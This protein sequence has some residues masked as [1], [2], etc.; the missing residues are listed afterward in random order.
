MTDVNGFRRRIT[1]LSD[2]YLKAL[3]DILGKGAT[4]RNEL[5][6]SNHDV[7]EFRK[8]VLLSDRHATDYYL[9]L[10]FQKYSHL[11][12]PDQL[13]C[14]R[15]K[16]TRQAIRSLGQLGELISICQHF[17]NRGL[18][19]T[20]IKGPHLARMLYGNSAVKVS[21]DLDILMVNPENLFDF[22]SVFINAGYS[23]YE[24]KLLTGSWKQK[25]YISAKREVHYFK[26]KSGCTIDL[27]VKP[28]ANTIITQHWCRNFFS[29]LQY[30]PFEGITIP[31]MPP[32]KYF[33][34]L[35][36]HGASHQFSRLGWLLD[37]RN[38]YNRQIEILRIDIILSV[39][40]Y[41]NTQRS[42]YLTFYLLEGMFND[43]MPEKIKKAMGPTGRTIEWL[44]MNCLKSISYEKGDNLTLRARFGRIVYLMKLT[45]DLAGKVDV[46]LSVF[47]RHLMQI[48]FGHKGGLIRKGD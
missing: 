14:L 30:L 29:D 4:G 5:V 31:V 38:F 16:I 8:L 10:Y 26:R 7:H 35:C 21:V 19:Y 32:E 11:I 45:K 12:L 25:L 46:V 22:H 43:P 20:I 34:Y 42:V 3:L 17:N 9:F 18:K 36:H 6:V 37:I 1:I 44:A 41:L 33:V 27:H 48:L 2:P 28:L 23:C 13:S 40:A 24:Q 47:L 15:D 39:A